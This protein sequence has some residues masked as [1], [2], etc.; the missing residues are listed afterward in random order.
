MNYSSQV[1]NVFFNA[2]MGNEKAKMWLY[3]NEHEELTAFVNGLFGLPNAEKWLLTTS[4]FQYLGHLSKAIKKDV[5]ALTW[6]I[7]HGYD[8]EAATTGMIHENHICEQWL[9]SNDRM[10]YLKMGEILRNKF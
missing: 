8:D 5:N 3:E 1:L 10:A 9:L 6:L 4:R 7:D 2:L